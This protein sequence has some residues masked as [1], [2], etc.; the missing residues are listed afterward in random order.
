MLVIV[1]QR[2][3]LGPCHIGVLGVQ[4]VVLETGA[5]AVVTLL[6]HTWLRAHP[7]AWTLKSSVR[8]FEQATIW[9][10]AMQS[11]TLSKK[12]LIVATWLKLF[13]TESSLR[14]ILKSNEF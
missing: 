13:L 6:T 4:G 14:N 9:S 5:E 8:E 3:A 2:V 12:D 1:E 7:M 11:S 10:K